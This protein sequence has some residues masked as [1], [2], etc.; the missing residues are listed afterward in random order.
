MHGSTR[1][2]M[3]ILFKV[4]AS[5][6]G[7]NRNINEPLD[8]INAINRGNINFMQSSTV[9]NFDATRSR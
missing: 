6:F 7:C 8:G 3:V 5:V 1:V 4:Y 9:V 2:V